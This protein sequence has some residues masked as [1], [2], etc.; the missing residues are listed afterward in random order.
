MLFAVLSLSSCIKQELDGAALQY[1]G[2]TL[3]LK[4]GVSQS[5]S[6]TPYEISTIR[7]IVFSDGK[8]VSNT[9]TH[10]TDDDS[11]K[12]ITKVA[13]GTNNF[14][15]ICNETLELETKLTSIASESSIEQINFQTEG[16][17]HSHIPMYGK[18]I[19][20]EV[21]RNPDGSSSITVN[22]IT[23][24][25]LTIP[26]DRLMVRL[27][28]TVIKN[29]TELTDKFTVESMSYKIYRIPKYMY[30]GK[31]IP[32]TDTQYQTDI[33]Q[34]GSGQL[35]VDGKY[36]QSGEIYIVKSGDA[37]TFPD[38]YLPEHILAAKS[39]VTH[40]TYMVVSANCI[41]DG[42]GIELNSIYNLNLGTRPPAN[43]DIKRSYHYN[44]FATIKNLGTM[45]FFA[46]MMPLVEY[47]TPIT[48]KPFEGYTIVS[49][50][51]ENYGIDQN[52]WN[53]YSQYYGLLKITRKNTTTNKSDV[54][55]ALFRYGSVVALSDKSAA[56]AF[57]STLFDPATNTTG[58]IL[59]CPTLT[60]T[61]TNWTN[62]GY[63]N[64]GDV[65]DAQHT[66]ANIALGKGDPCR[67]V[68]LSNEQ[69][70]NNIID[71]KL[72]RTATKEQMQWLIEARDVSGVSSP[73]GF[74][75][76]GQN[77]ILTPK[78]YGKRNAADGS[79]TLAADAGTYWSSTAANL[80]SFSTIDNTAQVGVSDM[81]EANSVRCV[82][83]TTQPSRFTVKGSS[84]GDNGTI[85]TTITNFYQDNFFVPFWKIT[86]WDSADGRL[87]FS[88]T[89]GNYFSSSNN[90]A[91]IFSLP[92]LDDV[93]SG[94]NYK[95]YIKGYGLDGV[96]HDQTV[97]ISQQSAGHP[98]TLKSNASGL[99]SADGATITFSIQIT[100]TPMQKYAVG[101]SEPYTAMEWYVE[102]VW[103]DHLGNYVVKTPITTA[104]NTTSITIPKNLSDDELGLTFTFR[105]TSNFTLPSYKGAEDIQIFAI[106]SK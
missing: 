104:L 76:F 39:D 23:T 8:I 41:M 29:T 31:D 101:G 93:Y 59:Y 71:N 65:D 30:I 91:P 103:S 54:Y 11:Y 25:E 77:T 99:I 21:K 78:T 88:K 44:L 46:E 52:I 61:P 51:A 73:N 26:V 87:T 100:G 83:T 24:S 105:R 69:I 14:Y 50:K 43:L 98:I 85:N 90:N 72:W 27:S 36:E 75:S 37:I 70:S 40:C 48:W 66:Q 86:H 64:T 7:L 47:N 18:I 58:D 38:V 56:G 9:L 89:F 60:T 57:N 34:N 33:Q 6:S 106:Q 5:L 63:L 79:M 96:I 4:F 94:K 62:V 74:S 16:V 49:E 95:V 92:P 22:G 82:R 28:M 84:A 20:G 80:F 53:D 55:P 3:D 2:S 42:S 35:L 1:T 97:T 10:I 67:L 19:G 81:A 32:F 15:A 12:I 102:A 13:L 17:D 68:G 45:G